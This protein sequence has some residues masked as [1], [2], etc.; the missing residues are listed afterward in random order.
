MVDKELIF[1][2]LFC[3]LLAAAVLA[4]ILAT[5]SDLIKVYAVAGFVGSLAA[6]VVAIAFFPTV[7]SLYFRFEAFFAFPGIDQMLASF[8][9]LMLPS[10]ILL[11]AGTTG[12]SLGISFVQL[13]NMEEELRRESAATLN[14][15]YLARL[16]SALFRG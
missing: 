15:R 11:S 3:Y 12:G 1:V 5:A 7:A 9:A 6:L 13:R 4:C 8:R 16:S 2:V 10:G 14:E